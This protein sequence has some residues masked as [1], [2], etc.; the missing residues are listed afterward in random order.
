MQL[1]ED[2]LSLIE[3]LARNEEMINEL[4]LVYS[5]KFS[6]E[7]EFWKNLAREELMHAAKVRNL[8]S[9]IGKNGFYFNKNRFKIETIKLFQDYLEEE[10]SNV[11]ST[12][13]INA[14]SVALDVETALLEYS[15]F[16]VIEGD[17]AEVR[18]ILLDLRNACIEHRNRVK[19]VWEEYR[20]K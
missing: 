20:N 1:K 11:S 4:Y 17:S 14:L 18:H 13:I 19:K 10:K 3:E 5:D 7:K 8:R 12:S 16:E 15:F 6:E 2:Q 9:E